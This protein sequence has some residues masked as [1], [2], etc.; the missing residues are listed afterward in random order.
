[1]KKWGFRLR[2]HPWDAEGKVMV[3]GFDV[4]KFVDS[5]LPPQQPPTWWAR[6][7]NSHD[8][9]FKAVEAKARQSRFFALTPY[10]FAMLRLTFWKCLYFYDLWREAYGPM[11]EAQMKVENLERIRFWTQVAFSSPRS[12]A[13]LIEEVAT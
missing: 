7:E 2:L 5:E 8:E 9:I 10:W 1:M 11:L 13:P 12:L 6:C 3:V 4:P